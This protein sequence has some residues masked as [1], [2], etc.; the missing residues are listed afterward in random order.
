MSDF[1]YSR[2]MLNRVLQ[3]AE[4]MDR[5]MEHLGVNA[6]TAARLDK[7]TAFYEARTRCIACHCERQCQNWL[8]RP[9]VEPSM[10]PPEFCHNSAFFR[11]CGGS[12]RA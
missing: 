6:A 10:E 4:L 7:G 8:R 2:P 3:Q 12:S 1:C 5:M 11:R 9:P